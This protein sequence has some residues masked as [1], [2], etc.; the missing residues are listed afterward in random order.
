MASVPLSLKKK[1]SARLGPRAGP[2]IMGQVLGLAS[3]FAFFS[4]F[5][6]VL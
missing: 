6:Y 5:L 3:F 2:L 4:L 1:R